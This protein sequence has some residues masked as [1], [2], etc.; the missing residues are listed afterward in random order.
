MHMR[1]TIPVLVAHFLLFAEYSS[2][3]QSNNV[4]PAQLR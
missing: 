4:S 1:Q 3:K 2:Q